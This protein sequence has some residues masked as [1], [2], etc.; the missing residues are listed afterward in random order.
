M[1]EVGR[2]VYESYASFLTLCA[3][4]LKGTVPL[5]TE[6]PVTV[7]LGNPFPTSGL[8]GNQASAIASFSENIVHMALVWGDNWC[9]A[10]GVGSDPPKREGG[11]RE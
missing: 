5:F 1:T 7:I 4:L 6:L 3:Y 2:R 8:L 10:Q 11:E 9:H